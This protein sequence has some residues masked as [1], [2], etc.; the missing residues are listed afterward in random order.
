MR[1]API[2]D[3]EQ[4]PP[5]PR[6]YQ[7][8]GVAI[9]I[10][11]PFALVWWSPGWEIL[12][13]L[14]VFYL[15]LTAHELG[16]WIAASRVGM[17]IGGFSV[18]GFMLVKS[19]GHWVFRFDARMLLAGW[20]KPLPA[21]EHGGRTAFAWMV[22]G[23]PLATCLLIAGSG[24]ALPFYGA[25]AQSWIGIV[26][27]IN[28]AL[29]VLSLL[30]VGGADGALLKL[31]LWNPEQSV[32]WIAMHQ[33]LTEEAHGVLPSEWNSESLDRML[34]MVPSCNGYGLCHLLAF[35][36]CIDEENDAA[37]VEH[38]ELSL[39]HSDRGGKIL[40]H[41]LYLEAACASA[42][43]RGD[44]RRAHVWLDRAKILRKPES[45]SAVLGAIAMAEGRYQD[46]L[47][48]HAESRRYLDRSKLDSGLARLA[49]KELAKLDCQCRLA[50]GNVGAP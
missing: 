46:A 29:L 12:L 23:G 3:L 9:G 48:L 45:E 2:L 24:L 32:A 1:P 34:K 22:A 50:L 42:A 36:R 8:I 17:D 7:G 11:L 6:K 35:Y 30:P 28:V 20:L 5:A 40:R 25:G 15:S 31:L 33:V 19:G 37:A 26:L 38:L 43:V 44:S 47:D 4:E 13:L 39:A 27:G 41:A 14:P 49:R 18:G 10:V 21:Q 16:H